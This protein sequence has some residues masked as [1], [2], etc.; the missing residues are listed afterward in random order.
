MRVT[1][2]LTQHRS[3]RF[4]AHHAYPGGEFR[5]ELLTHIGQT[6]EGCS[7]IKGGTDARLVKCSFNRTKIW[8][9]LLE[10]SDVDTQHALVDASDGMIYVDRQTRFN[11]DGKPNNG[12]GNACLTKWIDDGVPPTV[13]VVS[14]RTSLKMYV[15]KDR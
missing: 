4:G 9:K 13:L 5:G 10:T 12:Q 7:W 6:C 3:S 11:L 2:H 1:S 14:N 15:A 8:S